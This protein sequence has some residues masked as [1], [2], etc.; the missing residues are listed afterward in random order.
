MGVSGIYS[1]YGT[2]RRRDPADAKLVVLGLFPFVNSVNDITNRANHTKASPID[3]F[4]QSNDKKI[5]SGQELSPIPI[6]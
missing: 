6:N 1:G 3:S 4:R 2:G 5:Y